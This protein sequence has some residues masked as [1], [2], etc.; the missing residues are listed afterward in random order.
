MMPITP[1]WVSELYH[2]LKNDA[3]FLFFRSASCQ[4]SIQR[5]GPSESFGTRHAPCFIE[6]GSSHK[7]ISVIFGFGRK[8]VDDDDDDDEDEVEL[9]LFQGALNGVEPDMKANAKLVQAGLMRAKELVTNALSRRAEMVRLEPKGQFSVSTMYVDGVPF[10]GSKMPS[11]AA[12][13]ITQMLKLL[14]GLDTKERTKP[15]TG[16][17]RAQYLDDKYEVRIDT[18]PTPG[19]ER[20]I[21]RSRNVK[22]NF[23]TPDELGWSE[24]LKLK[25][26][27][28]TSLKKGIILAAGLPMSGVSSA[29]FGLLRSIDAYLF[30]I[31][32]VAKTGKDIAHVAEF[33]PE[34]GDTI[35]QTMVRAIRAEGDVLFVPPVRDSEFAKIMLEES[36]EA[37]L[38]SEITAKDSADAISRFTQLTEDP[39][40]CAE[41]IHGVISQKLVRLLCTACRQAYRPNPK[42]LQKVGLPPET[43]VLYRAPRPDEEEDK[44]EEPEVCEKCGG[45]GYFGRSG[46]VEFIEIN[47]AIKAIIEA[48]ADAS[49]IREQAKKDRM[50]S[51]QSDG[52][53]LV[54]AGKT[55]L[56]ELQRVFKAA[57]N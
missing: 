14:A 48:G 31:Y 39:I 47:E 57:S 50:Q 6:L 25:I 10:P 23:E 35:Q 16:A 51:W 53:R 24:E 42:L 5:W 56:E 18:S 54:A 20:L 28:L 15:Q 40:Q 46:L 44:D 13:A 34:E 38:I 17:L 26:R 43:K 12:L 52:M 1:S 8:Q 55:S 36:E 11:Q 9:V 3:G 32:S 19:G 41:R 21:I 49:K 2:S 30:N 37:C 33:Q 27:E 22:H 45:V 7:G 29:A 4:N